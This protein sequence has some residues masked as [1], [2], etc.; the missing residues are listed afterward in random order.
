MSP[1]LVESLSALGSSPVLIPNGC[2]PALFAAT[3]TPP[4]DEPRTV[5]YVGHLSDRVDIGL[6]SA[7]ADR[8]IRLRIIGPHQ[9]TLSGGDFDSLAAR[10]NVVLTGAV[11]YDRLPEELAGVTTCVL[12]YADTAFN[13]AS[14]PLKLLEYLAAGRRVVSTDLPAAR[15]LETDLVD[16]ASTTESFVAAVEASLASPLR[17]NEIERRRAFAAQH[18]WESRGRTLAQAIGLVDAEQPVR[19]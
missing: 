10:P 13:R 9:E 2:D 6:L 3:P 1:Q 5:A 7:L 16:R 4:P 8:G 17:E 15:W 11:P 12:P 18:S 14:F 19:T